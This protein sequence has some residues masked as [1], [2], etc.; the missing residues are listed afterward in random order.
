MPV[1][2]GEKAARY[3]VLAMMAL[4]YLLI[5]YLVITGYFTPV[6]LVVFLAAFTWGRVWAM[7]QH[8]KPDE[9]PA[10]YD[11]STWPL[12]FSATAFYQNRAY[13]LFLMIGL[14]LELALRA[15]K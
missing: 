14:L 8:P 2:M 4:Q 10:N 7:F 9:R 11:E 1:L 12:W 6:M 13:G 5:V 15:I 3:T